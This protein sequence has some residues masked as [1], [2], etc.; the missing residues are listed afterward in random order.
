MMYD[1]E[2]AFSLDQAVTAAGTVNSTDVY[3][4]GVDLNI[5]TNRELQVFAEV[6]EAFAGGTSVN[7]Q[8]VESDNEDLSAGDVLAE[9]GAI[10]VADLADDY[11][12]FAQAL[13]RTSKRYLGFQ[14]VSVG[15]FTAGK[16]SGG[17]VRDIQD[18]AFPTHHTGYLD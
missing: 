10:D 4:A 17:L 9:S 3:D 16:F 7:L 6:T 13:P 18:V 2:T 11:R 5:N 12:F 14:I 1:R 8:L 15:T